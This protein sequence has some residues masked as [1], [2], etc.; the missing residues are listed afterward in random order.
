MT[1]HQRQ[2]DHY[3]EVKRRIASAGLKPRAND[4]DRV[5]LIAVESDV[6]GWTVRPTKFDAHVTAYRIAVVTPKRNHVI[7]RAKDFGLTMSE[8][9]AKTRKVGIVTARQIIML[10]I[11]EMWPNTSLAEIG[12]IFGG[13]HHTTVLSA[14][15]R[16]DD[17]RSGRAAVPKPKA[18]KVPPKSSGCFGPGKKINPDVQDKIIEMFRDGQTRSQIAGEFGLAYKTIGALL[19]R[20]GVTA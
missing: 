3:A 13:L 20:R 15:R 11:K 8:I 2:Y 16:A 9:T 7:D 1:E 19:K 10:E 14:L 5:R 17:F 6:P 4:N 12:N 18:P